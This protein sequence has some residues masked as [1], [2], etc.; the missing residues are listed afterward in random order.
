M[1]LAW[2]ATLKGVKDYL[3][4]FYSAI[5]TTKD[6]KTVRECKDKVTM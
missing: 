4:D 2:M 1:I 3:D 6:V 5:K